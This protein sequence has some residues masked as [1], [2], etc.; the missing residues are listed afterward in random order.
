MGI[1][2]EALRV[3]SIELKN[4]L[5]KC[6][7]NEHHLKKR[8]MQWKIKITKAKPNQGHERNHRQ[9]KCLLKPQILRILFYR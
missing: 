7:K 8:T 5:T 9:G 1:N 3:R 4:E 2:H 6:I